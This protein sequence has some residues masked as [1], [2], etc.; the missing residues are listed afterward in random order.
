[1]KQKDSVK[2]ITSSI[3]KT[4]LTE[5]I[6]LNNT[7][8]TEEI[9]ESLIWNLKTISETKNKIN[10]ITDK[11]IQTIKYK[12]TENIII[13]ELNNILHLSR[14][15][16][17][18]IS[19]ALETKL[20]KKTDQAIT[21]SILRTVLAEEIPHDY[22]A[23]TEET[24]NN[25]IVKLNPYFISENENKKDLETKIL[26]ELTDILLLLSDDVQSKKIKINQEK[27]K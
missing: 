9:V 10:D 7:I 13:D 11:M 3:V 8:L 22:I 2:P 21:T 25:L 6:Y 1:M 4:L 17:Y 14:E 20:C 5:E 19:K 16:G 18:S 26:I 24:I 27:N 23:L 15:Q 12:D